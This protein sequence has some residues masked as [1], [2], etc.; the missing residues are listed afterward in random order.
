MPILNRLKP[1]LKLEPSF[2]MKVV[3]SIMGLFFQS[4][5]LFVVTIFWASWLGDVGFG[6]YSHAWSIVLIISS[7]ASFGFPLLV[8]RELPRIIVQIKQISYLY[9]DNFTNF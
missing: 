9:I 1:N 2:S 7:L 8:Q 5:V 4:G 3:Q 6:R